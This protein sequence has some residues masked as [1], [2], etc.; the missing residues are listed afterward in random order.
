[1]RCAAVVQQLGVL[2]LVRSGSCA[3]A[4]MQRLRVGCH[5]LSGLIN[6]RRCASCQAYPLRRITSAHSPGRRE[7][8]CGTCVLGSTLPLAC[9]SRQCAACQG[10]C[11]G[12]FCS[13]SLLSHKR[14]R[15]TEEAAGAGKAICQGATGREHLCRTGS[16]SQELLHAGQRHVC[17]GSLVQ[18]TCAP[19]KRD[20]P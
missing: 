2:H 8:G 4:A 14:L 7:R 9:G 19:G 20:V 6:T 17:T 3:P 10:R 16:A 11:P 18:C 15:S 12:G 1:M 13:S 5:V